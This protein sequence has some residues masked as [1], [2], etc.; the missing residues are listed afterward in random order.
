MKKAIPMA[1]ATLL[2]LITMV[3]VIVLGASMQTASFSLGLIATEV[4]CIFLPAMLL[5]QGKK[6]NVRE[7]L[8]LRWP[9]WQMAGLCVL[10]GIAVWSLDVLID[11]VMAQILGYSIGLPPAAFPT[12][13][14]SAV[15]VMIGLAVAAPICEEILFRGVLQRSFEARGAKF[16][17]VMTAL[18]FIFYH[19]R[20]QGL[21]ALLPV[22]LLLGYV[23]KCTG[24]LVATMLVHFGNNVIA[25]IMMVVA[26]M[27]PDLSQ[28]MG[29][30]Y[31]VLPVAGVPLLAYGLWVLRHNK[32]LEDTAAMEEPVQPEG[33][34]RR[35]W[36]LGVAAGIYLVLA[37]SE[38]IWGM[39]PGLLAFNRPLELGAMRLEKPI[40]LE[41]KAFNRFDEPVGNVTCS[42]KPE[43]GEAA[44]E[45][46]QTIQAFNS[47]RN[48][49]TWVSG[50]F[51]RSLQARWLLADMSLVDVRNTQRNEDRSFKTVHITKENEQY[52][53]EVTGTSSSTLIFNEALV[54]E[55]WMWQLS[56]MAFD[57]QGAQLAPFIWPARWDETLQKSVISQTSQPVLLLGGE[58]LTLPAGN[59]TTWKVEVNQ[60]DRLSA[61]Y[62]AETHLPVQWTDYFFTYKLVS[63]K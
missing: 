30:F 51:M 58:P 5:L 18:L 57:A 20:F 17:L 61:W 11:G 33:F 42:L 8:R 41:Y 31:L 6:V 63:Q 15:L 3:L 62:D 36:P 12:D 50:A 37:I 56:G 29:W 38:I 7:S 55:F 27:R 19:M 47:T 60:E 10:L 24:S 34:L 39:F 40:I 46:T 9:G 43:N 32:P 52:S 14:S 59:F 48:G 1:D 45:C 13:W 44:L 26:S 22:A 54:D 35:Y 4:V 49:T 28:Q 23:L 16:A 25:G 2:F 21:L 53:I